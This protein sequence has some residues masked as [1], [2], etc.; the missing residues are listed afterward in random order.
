MCRSNRPTH[1]RR[2]GDRTAEA[3]IVANQRAPDIVCRQRMASLQNRV[4]DEAGTA[5]NGGRL[6]TQLQVVGRGVHRIHPTMLW[7]ILLII[8]IVLLVGGVGYRRRW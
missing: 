1:R 5:P 6:A 7:L 2:V 4:A 3:D 8:L